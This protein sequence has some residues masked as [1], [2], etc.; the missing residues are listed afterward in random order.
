[1][2]LPN[3]RTID[4]DGR[5]YPYLIKKGKGAASVRLTVDLGDNAYLQANFTFSNLEAML[6]N[7]QDP[8]RGFTPAEVYA[9]IKAAPRGV[10][11]EDF[12][13]AN[14]VYHPASSK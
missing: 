14:W 1:M 13:L 4:V 11:P 6:E 3:V 2:T 8:R 12:E 10:L 7:L 9:V 5:I